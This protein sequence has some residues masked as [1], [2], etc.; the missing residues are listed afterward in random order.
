MFK[1][2]ASLFNK[3]TELETYAD[4]LEKSN[5]YY[6]KHS[7]AILSQCVTMGPDMFSKIKKGGRRNLTNDINS[8]RKALKDEGKESFLIFTKGSKME[9]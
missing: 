9:N 4:M 1:Y 2:I 7:K 6:A 5:D 3:K 8:K